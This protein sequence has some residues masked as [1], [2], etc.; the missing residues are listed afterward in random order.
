[1]FSLDSDPDSNLAKSVKTAK[2]FKGIV[3]EVDAQ[4]VQTGDKK[5]KPKAPK[6]QVKV[7]APDLDFD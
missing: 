2:A 6:K 5:K 1:M 7:I 4:E 3:K